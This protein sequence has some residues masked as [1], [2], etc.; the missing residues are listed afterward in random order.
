M[1]LS[2]ELF[3]KIR[4]EMENNEYPNEVEIYYYENCDNRVYI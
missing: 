3:E 4:N 1:G 2:K